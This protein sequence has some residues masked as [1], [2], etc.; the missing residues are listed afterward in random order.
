M[1]NGVELAG[2]SLDV[3]DRVERG[4]GRSFDHR[5]TTKPVVRVLLLTQ[6]KSVVGSSIVEVSWQALS[7]TGAVVQLLISCVMRTV[8]C[9]RLA[10]AH[11]CAATETIETPVLHC[12]TPVLLC[13]ALVA[14]TL[15]ETLS[16]DAAPKTPPQIVAVNAWLPTFILPRGFAIFA[17]SFAVHECGTWTRH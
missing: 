5:R 1:F 2:W 10:L 16:F 14:T 13:V 9:W 11:V 8:R 12:S 3:R 6:S 7:C 17:I 4:V 15:S